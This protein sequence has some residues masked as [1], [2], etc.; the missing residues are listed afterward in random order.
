MFK[1]GCFLFGSMARGDSDTASDIDILIVYDHKPPSV[2]RLRVKTLIQEKLEQT[3]TFSEYT[4]ERLMRM[5]SEGH[6]FAWHL[7][8]EA[9]RLS[10]FGIEEKTFHFP[11]PA[12]YISTL[13]DTESFL[14]LLDSC[15]D[16]IS[17]NTVSLVY[18]AGLA[19]LAIRNIGIS[20]GAK[21]LP[22]PEFDRYVPFKVAVTLGIAPPCS[23]D[24]YDLLV[25]ARHSSQRGLS[26]PNLKAERLLPELHHTRNWVKEALELPQ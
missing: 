19:Y 5:F 20:L 24:I 14:A 17:K 11:E 8:Y 2:H 13:P 10:I 16:A 7:Y 25:A 15:I 26:T 6:L 1:T 4:N 21:V 23:K 3:C 22:R 12:Q 18:E 9:R